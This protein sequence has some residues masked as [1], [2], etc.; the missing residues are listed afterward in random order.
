[1]SVGLAVIVTNVLPEPAGGV[2]VKGPNVSGAG[3]EFRSQ[4]VRADMAVLFAAG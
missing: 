3:P 2:P 1:M 4:R